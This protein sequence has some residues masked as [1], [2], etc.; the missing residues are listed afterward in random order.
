MSQVA[1]GAQHMRASSRPGGA[2]F[3]VPPATV[4]AY[5]ERLRAAGY[6]TFTDTKLDYQFS[7]P[8]AGSGPSSIW[9]DEGR[10]TSW[11]ARDPGQPFFGFINFAVAPLA[12]APVLLAHEIVT[13]F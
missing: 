3:A 4:K 1:I 8:M 12:S 6:Y 11:R 2:Y 10:G 9:D 7:G 5:P 13:T